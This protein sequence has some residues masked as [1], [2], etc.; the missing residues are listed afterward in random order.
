MGQLLDQTKRSQ[1]RADNFDLALFLRITITL[2]MRA[3]KRRREISS[4][5]PYF[6]LKRL[7]AITHR[8]R[9]FVSLP[10]NAESLRAQHRRRF[11]FHFAEYFSEFA[12]SAFARYVNITV[13]LWSL[14][15]SAT[16]HA[17]RRK[18][19]GSRR[20]DDRW[21]PQRTRKING[22]QTAGA[23]KRQQRKLSRIVTTLDRNVS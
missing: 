19:A 10:S 22:V 15:T 4:R 1:P 16:R 14:I 13:R 11:P 20:H 2:A 8:Q 17:D 12:Q 9:T 3:M 18:R 5:I 7:P 6:Q 21:N 23:A